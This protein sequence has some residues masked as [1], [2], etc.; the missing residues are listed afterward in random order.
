MILFRYDEE[1]TYT[2]YVLYDAI[3]G[4]VLDRM[5]NIAICYDNM[6]N[7]PDSY[8]IM[9]KFGSPDCVKPWHEKAQAAYLGELSSD[10]C[11]VYGK[12]E[13]EE[14]NKCIECTGYLKKL[15]DSGYFE[16][17]QIDGEFKKLS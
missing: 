10:L 17:T 12:Y 2:P 16:H 7:A 9:M 1:D 6:G 13:V 8:P 5:E 15:V 3:T 11:Y 14:I 4:D